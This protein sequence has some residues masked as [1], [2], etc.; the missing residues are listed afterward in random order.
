VIFHNLYPLAG[1]MIF[2]SLRLP[3]LAFTLQL[4][5]Q[6]LI[7]QRRNHTLCITI[8]NWI[9]TEVSEGSITR[10]LKIER[11]LS[12]QEVMAFLGSTLSLIDQRH[13]SLKTQALTPHRVDELVT[14]HNVMWNRLR[15][16]ISVLCQAKQCYNLQQ[17]F[18][19]CLIFPIFIVFI[20]N[21]ACNHSAAATPTQLTRL[22]THFLSDSHSDCTCISSIYRQWLHL[23]MTQIVIRIY[24]S[25]WL[26]EDLY[27]LE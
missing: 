18:M 14:R 1:R 16:M 22:L 19:E 4:N 23:I 21:T 24:D 12:C 10:G 26:R 27:K 2:R 17:I 13:V 15:G 7:Y 25:V 5:I 6:M 11:Q 20:P 9:Q 3:F 8:A